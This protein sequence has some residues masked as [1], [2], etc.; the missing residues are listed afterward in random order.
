MVVGP[1]INGTVGGFRVFVALPSR[2][3]YE[4]V[5]FLISACLSRIYNP[6]F[7]GKRQQ[8]ACLGIREAGGL[9][10]QGRLDVREEEFDANLDSFSWSDLNTI[11]AAMRCCPG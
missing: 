5:Y 1:N 2:K 10:V 4:P 8:S 6:A 11:A 3:T 9:A 7:R